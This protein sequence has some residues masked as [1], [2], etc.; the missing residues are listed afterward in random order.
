M[1]GDFV[2]GGTVGGGWAEEG[3]DE[4]LCFRGDGVAGGEIVL[5]IFD[6]STVNDGP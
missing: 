2:Y 4:V 3:G 5:I 1:V 6:F